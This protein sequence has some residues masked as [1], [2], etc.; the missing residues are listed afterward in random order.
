[1]GHRPVFSHQPDILRPILEDDLV[2][3]PFPQ[4]RLR[5]VEPNLRGDADAPEVGNLNGEAKLA[6]Q[7][8]Q[9][10]RGTPHTRTRED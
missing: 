5:E 6:V 8:P 9:I 3:V 2:P 1:M 10:A 4:Q 7:R